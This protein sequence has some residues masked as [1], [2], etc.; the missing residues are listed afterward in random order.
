MNVSIDWC[1]A[2]FDFGAEMLRPLINELSR[3]LGVPLQAGEGRARPG[4]TDGLEIKAFVRFQLVTVAVLA[5]GGDSQRGRAMLEFSGGCC[6][7]VCDWSTMRDFLESLPGSRLTRVDVAVDLFEGEY[8]V[9]D[10]IAWRDEGFFTVKGR[11]PSSSVAGDWYDRQAGRTLYIGKAKNGKG[12]R[13]YEK[14]QQ[15][16]FVDSKWNRFEVQ[17]G[18]RERVLPFDILLTP[19]KYFV[20]AYPALERLLD[21]VG[22]PIHLV[23]R[24]AE[25]SIRALLDHFK[26]GY[27]KWINVFALAGIDASDLVAGLR[28]MA[29]PRR[30][31]ASAVVA[32]VLASATRASFDKWV[33][34]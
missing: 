2:T 19:E 18:N 34:L 32:D 25:V 33:Q 27:G 5:Y 13:V 7:C 26:R 14:G 22:E 8:T 3:V 9:D 29:L 1:A 16:G 30:I 24:T 15:L 10:A 6:G 17:F 31:Q 20:G 4:F 12:L 21:Q 11:S 28:V 23:S